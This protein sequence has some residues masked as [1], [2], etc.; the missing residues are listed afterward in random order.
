MRNSGMAHH[1]QKS[2]D[3]LVRGFVSVLSALIRVSAVY[4]VTL[5][6]V[7][8]QR[9]QALR[10]W[11][12]NTEYCKFGKSRRIDGRMECERFMVRE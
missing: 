12:L 11:P 1:K 10:R 8:M 9:A 3:S 2:P 4:L 7:F 5:A 6:L